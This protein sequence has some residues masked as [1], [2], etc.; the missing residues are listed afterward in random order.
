MKYLLFFHLEKLMPLILE[1]N[2][3]LRMTDANSFYFR[4]VISALVGS[5]IVIQE[6]CLPSQESK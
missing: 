2:S 4:N 6:A 5:G 3:V 1:R